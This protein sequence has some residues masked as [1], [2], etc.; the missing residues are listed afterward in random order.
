VEGVKDMKAVPLALAV[1]VQLMSSASAQ[2]G[3]GLPSCE[4]NYQEFWMRMSSGAA[5]EMSGEQFAKLSRYALRVYDGCTSGDGRFAG[6]GLFKRLE[7]SIPQ[8]QISPIRSSK[9][10]FPHNADARPADKPY[11]RLPTRS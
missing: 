1:L 4:R 3:S 9:S 10:P 2:I 5:K 7:Q 11:R 6:D 8:R